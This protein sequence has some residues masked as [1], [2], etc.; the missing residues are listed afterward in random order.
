MKPDLHKFTGNVQPLTAN[1]WPG[2]PDY[3]NY[4]NIDFIKGIL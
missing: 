3:F 1:T 2:I 4:L